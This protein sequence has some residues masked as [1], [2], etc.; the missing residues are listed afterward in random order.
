MSGINNIT[1]GIVKPNTSSGGNGQNG[2]PIPFLDLKLVEKGSQNDI[3]N[4]NLNV[5]Q[6]G[7]FVQGM[8]NSKTVW[9][10]AMYNGG[11][12]IDRNN[13]TPIVEID[14]EDYLQPLPDPIIDPENP[15]IPPVPGTPDFA[16]IDFTAT[17]FKTT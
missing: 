12:P 15:P 7:D 11:D 16:P 2:F 3:P 14:L 10:S 17:D 6:I 5:L 1:I 4:T 13:Y 9:K 8:K